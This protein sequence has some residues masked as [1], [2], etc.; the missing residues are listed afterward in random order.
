M[1]SQPYRRPSARR[2]GLR[3]ALWGLAALVL[4]IPAVAMQFSR[5]VAWGAG[6]FL[7]AALLLGAT[8]LAVELAVAWLRSPAQRYAAAGAIIAVLLFVWA[9]LAV[10]ILR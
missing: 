10:G 2:T 4:L 7:A 9:E 8:G 3:R 1:P 5:Q 6:D